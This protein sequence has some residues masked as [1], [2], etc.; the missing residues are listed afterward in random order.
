MNPDVVGWFAAFLLTLMVEQIVATPV[1]A[2]S[3]A[4]WFRR[5]GVVSLANLATHP[6][7]WFAF[8]KL[9]LSATGRL[10]TAEL[11]ALSIETSAYL[12]V[13][14]TLRPIRAFA[15]SALANGAS[16]GVG[17]SLRALGVRI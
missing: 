17:L 4:G 1:L 2:P 10:V 7:V 3:G 13:W 12:L 9:G 5:A 6:L 11:F 8:P 15:A 14:P 16:L